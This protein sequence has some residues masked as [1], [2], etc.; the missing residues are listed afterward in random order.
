MY[1]VCGG[2]DS[3]IVVALIH[4]VLELSSFSPG[5]Q[6]IPRVQVFLPV[7]EK[8]VGG[9]PNPVDQYCAKSSTP[10]SVVTLPPFTILGH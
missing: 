1:V 3:V 2:R 8:P 10:L 4:T 7:E 5:M 6:N 9:T